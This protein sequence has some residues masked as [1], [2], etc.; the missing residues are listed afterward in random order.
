M[1]RLVKTLLLLPLVA[2]F[3]VVGCS[4]RKPETTTPTPVSSGPAIGVILPDRVTSQ[5]WTDFDPVF[6]AKAFTKA[7]VAADIQ[8]AEGSPARFVQ[9]GEQMI[10]RRVKVLI[11]ASL[12]S[13]SGS[14]VVRLA[15]SKGIYTIDYDRLTVGGGADYYVSF[16]NVLVGVLQGQA[17]LKCL[18]ERKLVDPIVSELHGSP[19]DNNAALYRQ[20]YDSVLQPQYDNAQMLKG[21]DQSVPD[22]NT[23]EARKIF[24]QMLDQ[25]PR[26]RGVV[27]ANDGIA[28]AVIGVLRA[29]GLAGA[30]PV[31]GQDAT[32]GGLQNVLRGW[33][34]M[35]VY[36]SIE[37]ESDAAAALA[38]GLLQGH[39][40]KVLGK[41]K[42]EE[43]GAYIPAI[44]LPSR[45]IYRSNIKLVL[46]DGLVSRQ[47]LCVRDVQ[48]LCDKY[49]S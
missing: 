21:P 6:L 35:T 19:S 24:T 26:I 3:A 46:D 48:K 12:D 44:L 5:R 8:N 23:D 29:R 7:G 16:D 20:G 9:I 38:I 36:K 22:W 42:D 14:R 15:K 30:V 25:Q 45:V 10:A 39:T 28:N 41:V 11:T 2:F 4:D 49:L 27:A 17:L 43:T 33:Q 13:E 34:C 47:Q 40:P 32:I 37:P 18:A 31:T 1:D